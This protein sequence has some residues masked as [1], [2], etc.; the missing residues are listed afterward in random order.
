MYSKA[1]VKPEVEMIYMCGVFMYKR[2]V[3]KQIKRGSQMHGLLQSLPDDDVWMTARDMKAEIEGVPPS[4]LEDYSE[5]EER[6]NKLAELGAV[7]RS[8]VEWA[9]DRYKVNPGY[10]ANRNTA[11]IVEE[12]IDDGYIMADGRYETMDNPPGLA[13]LQYYYDYDAAQLIQ[14][15]DSWDEKLITCE[16]VASFKPES[17]NAVAN[18]PFETAMAKINGGIWIPV[19]RTDA[20]PTDAKPT[21]VD[22]AAWQLA[23]H[24]QKLIDYG[25]DRQTIEK[26]LIEV[27]E[28]L[29]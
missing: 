16:I 8:S 20:K 25:M 27:P 12:N 13:I 10:S 26:A 21:D 19:T 17:T 22:R 2:M 18:V 7:E 5:F 14:V 28:R 24:A 15:M 29:E 11:E 23:D 4:E 1:H 9:L 3:D 6:L